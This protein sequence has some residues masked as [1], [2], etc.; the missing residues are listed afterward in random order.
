MAVLQSQGVHHITLNGADRQTSIDFWAS[1][2][3]CDSTP[4]REVFADIHHDIW[5]GCTGSSAVEL[6]SIIG[7]GHS[8]PGGQRG[9]LRAD[10]PSMTLSASQVIWD[11]FNAH[12][13]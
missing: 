8:W 12:P 3:G 1:F 11:F 6:Y 5:E 7:G 13:R 9:S 2:N 4:Q 10:Q